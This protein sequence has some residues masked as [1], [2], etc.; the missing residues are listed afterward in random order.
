MIG[1]TVMKK[2][3]TCFCTDV[4]HEGHINIINEAAK[5]GEVIVG[6]LSDE[7]MIRFNRFPTIDFEERMNL[8][9]NLDTVSQVVV[10]N[11]VMYDQIIGEL[12]PDVVIHGDNWLDGPMKAIRDNVAGL[13]SEYGG[14]II[15]VPF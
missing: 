2:V 8:V 7:A 15:D 3:Y 13:L 6:V 1:E 14:K 4:I 12:H 9:K 5:Y 11:D 10:Q